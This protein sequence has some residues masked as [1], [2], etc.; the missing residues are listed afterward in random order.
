LDK[1]QKIMRRLFVFLAF[2]ALAGSIV[3]FSCQKNVSNDGKARLQVFL[4]DDPGDYEAVFIDVQDVMINVTDDTSSGWQSLDGV[5]AGV[6]DLLTLINDD[7]TLLADA[8]IPTGNVSQIRLVLGT[9]NYVKLEGDPTL[10]KLETPS[11][12][13]SGLKLNIHMDV[14]EGVLYKLIMDFDVNKSIVKTGNGKYMLKP[15]IRTTLEA[16]GGSIRGVVMPDTV[17]TTVYAVQG[18]DTITSTFTG[19]NGGYLIKGLAAG[20]YDLHYNPSNNT[21]MDSIRTG[22]IVNTGQV[23]VVDTTWLHQ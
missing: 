14:L 7:D 13:Q 17:Q 1:K 21:Y 2:I 20:S 11:A 19:T 9:E 12:Q 5:N 4:T 15:V 23:T 22:I 16:V 3:F 18:P 6:Y 10:I 8:L